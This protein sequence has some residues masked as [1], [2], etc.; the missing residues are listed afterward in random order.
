MAGL[1]PSRLYWPV[2]YYTGGI[3]G[4]GS[5]G[6]VAEFKARV[7]NDFVA[8]NSINSVIE[9]GCGNGDQLSLA[10]YP[11]YVGIDISRTAIAQCRKRF[12]GDRTKA[13]T[14]LRDYRASVHDLAISLEVIFHHDA[15][16]WS[17]QIRHRA[18]SR[19][20]EANRPEWKLISVIPNES[21]WPPELS[22]SNF[23]VYG[24]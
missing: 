9:F 15:P 7:L 20:V 17:F 3:S 4:P 21:D 11:R 22:F 8:K 23:H 6:R 13:F 18:F 10:R 16:S 5:R 19:W 14:L 1:L 12:Q 24:R 2:R